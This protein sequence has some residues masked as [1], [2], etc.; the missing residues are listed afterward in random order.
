MQTA[1]FHIVYNPAMPL[2]SSS[3]LRYCLA[4]LVL[5]T[6]WV[7]GTHSYEVQSAQDNCDIALSLDAD[8]HSDDHSD[9]DAPLA[10]VQFIHS[11]SPARYQ[12]QDRARVFVP[13]RSS[14]PDHPPPESV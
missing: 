6:L 2:L 10:R 12:P 9:R 8:S 11:A 4:V 14:P 3:L 7:G 1:I 13:S 5:L